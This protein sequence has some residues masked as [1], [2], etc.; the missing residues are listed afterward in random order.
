MLETS[1]TVQ[2][3]NKV[4]Q[5]QLREALLASMD[6]ED[7]IDFCISNEWIG[8]LEQLLRKDRFL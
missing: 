7:A 8:V 5:A 6:R 3:G 4:Y 1:L 2:H